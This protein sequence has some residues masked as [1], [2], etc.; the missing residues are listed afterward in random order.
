[1]NIFKIIALSFTVFLCCA[2]FLYNPELSSWSYEIAPSGSRAIYQIFFSYPISIFFYFFAEA[3]IFL[4]V[5]PIYALYTQKITFFMSSGL[6]FCLYCSLWSA[7]YQKALFATEPGGFI[8]IQL[9]LLA[10]RLLE[11]SLIKLFLTSFF[12]AG[13]IYYAGSF[14]SLEKKS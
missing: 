4:C 5:I 11:P 1:M 8:G 12:W 10:Q 3:S 6:Y 2:I 13:I 9:A 14:F 7:F